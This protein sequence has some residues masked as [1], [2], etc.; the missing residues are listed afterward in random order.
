[1]KTNIRAIYCIGRNYG[2]HAKELGNAVP[3]SPVVF[4]KSPSAVR[5]VADQGRIA[6]LDETFHHEI[7]LVLRIGHAEAA[8]S[9]LNRVDAVALGLDL[10]RR[11]VQNRLKKEGLPWTEAKSF[12]GAAV[13]SSFV[14]LDEKTLSTIEDSEF[15]LWVNGEKRQ[16]GCPRGMIFNL[17]TLL[18]TIRDSHGLFPG[19]IL[20]TGTPEGVGPLRPGD[21]F[22]MQLTLNGK[23]LLDEEGVL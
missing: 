20:F 11:E 18:K 19:D 14:P 21:H 8:G 4:L 15:T 5:G 22:R 9:L 23:S 17:E 2:A 3:A 12:V 7:E 10:T 1:M 6:Y 13:L 16:H